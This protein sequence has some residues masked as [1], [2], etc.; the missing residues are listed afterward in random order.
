ML[1]ATS[2]PPADQETV[3]GKRIPDFHLNDLDNHDKSFSELRG[4]VT[5]VNFWATWCIPCRAE[6]PDLDALYRDY[7]DRGLV[8]VGIARDPQPD[9]VR[10]FLT[11]QVE[12]SYPN[13]MADQAVE[14]LFGGIPGLP[15]T[16]L[17]DREGVVREQFIGFRYRHTYEEAVRKLLAEQSASKPDAARGLSFGR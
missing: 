1:G 15:T 13:L 12:V 4:T 2:L 5:L 11:E 6:M 9:P 8:V 3:V 14:E 7:K 10:E 17:L 16:F